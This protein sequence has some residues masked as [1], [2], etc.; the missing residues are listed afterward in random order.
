MHCGS[1]AGREREKELTTKEALNLCKDLAELGANLITLMGGEPFLRRDWNEIANEIKDYGMKLTI[2]SN[3]FLINEGLVSKLKKLEP[4]AVAISIDGKQTHDEIRGVKNSFNRCINAINLL[5]EEDIPT[6][7]ITTVHKKNLHELKDIKDIII[8][9]EIAWQIQ[10]ATPIGR[11]KKQ[12]LLSKE[13]FY[14]VALFIAMLRKK[15]SLKQLPVFGAH[16]FGYFSKILPNIMLFPWK[17]CQAGIST[18]GITSNG[19][20]KGCLSLPDDYIEGNIRNK[21]IFE[22][23]ED[24]NAFSYNRKFTMED[25]GGK[26]RN[27]RFGK[28]CK[29]GC[30]TVSTTLTGKPHADP[31][32]LHLIEKELGLIKK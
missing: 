13:E 11:F 19:N 29:G 1:S 9:K 28:K 22:I 6:T 2:I 8:G 16:N 26:C 12:F 5:R 24:E 4:Y 23:W 14:S 32:C 30:M 20:I 15:Y 17:G 7:V 21:S 27:C 3:G 25:L 31:Y 18:I 10:M